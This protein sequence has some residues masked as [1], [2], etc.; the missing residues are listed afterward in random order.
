MIKVHQQGKDLRVKV[1][2][3]LADMK[4]NLPNNKSKN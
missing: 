3:T 1:N 2:L 4:K